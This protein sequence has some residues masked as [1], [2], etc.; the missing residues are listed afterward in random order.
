[1]KNN[2]NRCY[3]K[4]SFLCNATND[5]LECLKFCRVMCPRA[6]RPLGIT[7][8]AQVKKRIAERERER[9]QY[10]VQ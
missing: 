10:F 6:E 1:M 4:H 5:H 8:E 9:E 3:H 2:I 7:K